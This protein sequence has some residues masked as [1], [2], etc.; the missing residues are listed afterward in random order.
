MS[1]NPFAASGEDPRYAPPV[2]ASVVPQPAPGALQ[3]IAI[4]CLILGLLGLFNSCAGGGGLALIS[5]IKGFLDQAPVTAENEF[6]K[7]NLDAAMSPAVLIP[8]IV[9]LIFN[10]VV[11]PILV[12][13]SIGVL[14]KKESGRKLLRLGLMLAIVYNILKAVLSIVAQLMT[15]NAAAAGI[16]AYEG[17]VE[18]EKLEGVLEMT[19]ILGL[20]GAIVAAI[21]AVALIGFYFWSRG[22]LNRQDVIKYFASF[23]KST[24]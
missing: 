2:S 24:V 4:L 20:G 14:Q 11:S 16:D 21:F 18:K 3:V 12:I 13:G 15:L 17:P 22:Y 10:F 6:Q 9:L 7:I 1:D 23:A 19:K 5:V 8:S